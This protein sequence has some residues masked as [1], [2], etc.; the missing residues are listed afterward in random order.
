[1]SKLLDVTVRP[2]YLP[3]YSDGTLWEA[4][5]MGSGFDELPSIQ[6]YG[7]VKRCYDTGEL[8]V[9]WPH[10]DQTSFVFLDEI[11]ASREE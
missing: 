4:H 6:Q 5:L 8:E 10:V 3:L 9:Y 2:R 1:M 7:V 11:C